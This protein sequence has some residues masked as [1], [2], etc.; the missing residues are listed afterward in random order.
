MELIIVGTGGHAKEVYDIAVRA[1]H[2]VVAFLNDIDTSR[3]TF[4]GIPVVHTEEE[5][6]EAGRIIV[7]VGDNTARQA[8]CERFAERLAPAL[9]DPSA[10]VSP[11]ARIASGTVV[12]MQATV[13]SDACVGVGV[14]VGSQAYIGHDTTVSGFSHVATG[15]ALNGG[16]TVGPRCL[17]GALTSIKPGVT[18]GDDVTIGMGSAV[19]ADL[20]DGLT[21]AGAPAREI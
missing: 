21:V 5:L 11:S 3:E 12:M 13:S 8:A 15:S 10:V 9:I 17:V 20:S 1:G 7:A 14:I 4:R 18:V 19:I 16:V 2:E 6:P